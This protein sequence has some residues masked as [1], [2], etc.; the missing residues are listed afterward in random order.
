MIHMEP[1]WFLAAPLFALA[2][3][4][5]GGAGKRSVAFA[6]VLLASLLVGYFVSPGLGVLGAAWIF[7]RSMSWTEWGTITPRT[8]GQVVLS[9]A[10][11]A[12]PAAIAAVCDLT[13]IGPKN[14][15]VT[16]FAYAVGATA[17]AVLYA[18]IV[19]GMAERGLFER[20]QVNQWI[21]LSRGGLYGAMLALPF[22]LQG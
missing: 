14:A 1:I 21:E 18:H 22:A 12:L 7:Y 2:D 19:D 16:L 9:L 13:A 20:G 15:V 10:H 6:V 4:V 17:L 8:G 3:R 5:V 11:N